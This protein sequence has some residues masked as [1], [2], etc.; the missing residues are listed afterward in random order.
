MK[1]E[2]V[3]TPMSLV[4]HLKDLKKSLVVMV[5]VFVVAFVGCYMYAPEIVSYMININTD[6]T[7]VQSDVTELLAQYIKVSLIAALVL[8]SPIIVWQI[9][10]FVS[11][12]LTR[13]EDAKFV[14]VLIG[15]LVFF[16]I[17]DLFCYTI[18]IPFTLQF[19]L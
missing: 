10:S 14:A 9:H 4:D 5:I 2:K 19:F 18:V 12:G 16:A 6:Y 1:K 17:G 15:G 11:P 8:D 13:S 7:F 3:D